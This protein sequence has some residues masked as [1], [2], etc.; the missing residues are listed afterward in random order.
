MVMGV[1]KGGLVPEEPGGFP[2]TALIGNLLGVLEVFLSLTPLCHHLQL[3]HP[4]PPPVIYRAAH[5]CPVP[6]RWWT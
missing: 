2:A 3:P 6:R 4:Q 5:S 1:G